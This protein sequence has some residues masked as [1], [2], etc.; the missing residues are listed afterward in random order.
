MLA[1]GFTPRLIADLVHARL[2]TARAEHIYAGAR[3]IA[4]T[5]IRITAAGRRALAVV[6][7]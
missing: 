2:A 6:G 1:H 5:R 3:A 7:R 4:I